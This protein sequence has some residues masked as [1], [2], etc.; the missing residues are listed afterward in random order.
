MLTT[1]WHLCFLT[2]N[3]TTES[4]V[5]VRA[6]PIRLHT[7]LR[8]EMDEWGQNCPPSQPKCISLP[9]S[10]SI[11]YTFKVF[12]KYGV[13]IVICLKTNPTRNT[14]HLLWAD[15]YIRSV[16]SCSYLSI[17]RLMGSTDQAVSTSEFHEYWWN[18]VV[19]IFLFPRFSAGPQKPQ[20]SK[21]KYE[22][23]GPKIKI[24]YSKIGI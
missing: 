8:I 19:F 2:E 11:H 16:C 13:S 7:F 10:M 14:F 22:N 1:L 6:G 24:P 15:L 9:C 12:I 23:F 3:S 18:N 17:R 4:T 20:T 21:S 5:L